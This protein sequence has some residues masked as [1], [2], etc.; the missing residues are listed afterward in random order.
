MIEGVFE[1]FT[2]ILIAQPAIREVEAFQ[3]QHPRR[4]GSVF[5]E[6]RRRGQEGLFDFEQ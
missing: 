4:P 2:S 3:I 6:V 1:Y 5:H